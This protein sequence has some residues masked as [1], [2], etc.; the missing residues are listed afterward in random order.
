MR[1]QL[2]DTVAFVHRIGL[3]TRHSHSFAFLHA[4]SIHVACSGWAEVVKLGAARSDKMSKNKTKMRAGAA[5]RGYG[6]T[7]KK[8]GEIQDVYAIGQIVRCDL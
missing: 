1:I 6:C 2:F 7:G 3:V 8:P 5:R 4:F